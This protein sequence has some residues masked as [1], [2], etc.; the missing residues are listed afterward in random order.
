MSQYDPVF[1][2]RIKV[3]HSKLYLWPRDYDC[4]ELMIRA[5]TLSDLIQIIDECDLYF[6]TTGF[7]SYLYH[8]FMDLHH[9]LVNGLG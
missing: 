9:T 1:D 3:R 2:I 4:L 7:D 5:N 6:C 8:H